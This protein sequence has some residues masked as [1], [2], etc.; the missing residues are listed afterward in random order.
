M[1]PRTHGIAESDESHGTYFVL[2]GRPLTQVKAFEHDVG[3]TRSLG[4]SLYLNYSADS[5]GVTRGKSHTARISVASKRRMVRSR[6]LREIKRGLA[7]VRNSSPFSNSRPFPESDLSP[8]PSAIPI[9]KA[10]RSDDA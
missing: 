3:R 1:R 7:K 4:S 9:P 6:H 8:L 2:A 10:N 5:L